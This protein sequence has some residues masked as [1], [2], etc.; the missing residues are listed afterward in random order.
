MNYT[1]WNNALATY[2]FN[3]SKGGKE[4]LL[5]VNEAKINA[6]GSS[7]GATIKDFIDALKNDSVH[8]DNTLC[9]RALKLYNNWRQNNSKYPPYVGYLALFVLAATTQGDFNESAYY[10]R[11]WK[12]IGTP[13]EGAPAFFYNTAVLW[14]DLE[15]WSREDKR[16]ELGRFNAR[17]RGNWRHVG[18]PLSQTLLSDDE[19]KVLPD[20]F[21]KC[22]FDPSNIP[23]DDIIKSGLIR[24]G[25][26]LGGR[27]RTLFERHEA[28]DQELANALID[29]VINELEDWGK[30]EYASPVSSE[31]KVDEE[32]KKKPGK[33]RAPLLFFRTCI[34]TDRSKQHISI[35]LRI[36]TAR[37]FPDNGLVFKINGKSLSCRETL[38]VGWSTKLMELPGNRLFNPSE[39]NWLEDS[40]FIDSDNMWSVTFKNSKIRL[41]LPGD[42]EGLSGFI[43]SQKL[44]RNCEFLIICD[45]SLVKSIMAWGQK[46]CKL[47]SIL[48]YSGIPKGWSLFKGID[49]FE[50]CQ[51]IDPLSLPNLLRIQ[52]EGGIK[53]GHSNLYLSFAPPRVKI[54]GGLGNEKLLLNGQVIE[55][56][57]DKVCWELKN[58]P[59]HLPLKIEIL[60][61]E[62]KL[63]ES[64]VIQLVEPSINIR[65]TS[66]APKR[67]PS[68]KVIRSDAVQDYVEGA[69]VVS[70]IQ[71]NIEVLLVKPTSLSENLIFIG[72]VAGQVSKWPIESLPI[73]W[74]PVWALFKTQ[75][76]TWGAEFCRRNLAEELTPIVTKEYSAEK[77][78][79]WKKALLTMRNS[80]VNLP[81]LEE[82]WRRY[83]E[84]ANNI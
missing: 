32:S 44:S 38:P 50:S 68:G 18:R 79:D 73:A 66:L 29:V 15:K 64:R 65:S 72:P 19:R 36:K 82:L 35:S 55:K 76:G 23:S 13:G 3:T 77:L 47:F 46:S 45:D 51:G 4:V 57:A 74:N 12:L 62:M 41:F 69:L 61:D 63:P 59:K 22:G 10:P 20:I 28:A 24:Y 67:D 37:P 26:L 58:A 30:H 70:S 83:M 17:I 84:V 25:K 52:L 6:L 42:E 71:E 8:A 53:L 60:R 9:K 48:N 27:T 43:E 31:Y 5:F 39:L 54:D 2:F 33:P 14:E 56:S 11:Y 81:A 78:R 21:F 34:E 1:E 80:R 75:R 16:E 49:A 40:K 7:R